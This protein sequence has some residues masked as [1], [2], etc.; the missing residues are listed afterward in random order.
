[1]AQR[2]IIIG[3]LVLAVACASVG[4]VV[5]RTRRSSPTNAAAAA[6]AAAAAVTDVDAS[7]TG[8]PTL[9][10]G[11]P[12]GWKSDG[13]GGVTG[14]RSVAE[15]SRMGHTGMAPTCQFWADCGG[16]HFEIDCS[17]AGSNRCRCDRT[18]GRSR[19]V[20]YD[21]AFCTLDSANASKSLDAILVKA[22]AVCGWTEQETVD[23]GSAR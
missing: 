1:M 14:F 15:C 7:I 22:A 4:A 12:L 11:V 8:P 10:C 2:R 19:V 9:W 3:S 20:S 16:A 6:A 18:N 21:P 17:S 23:G 5:L 13:D